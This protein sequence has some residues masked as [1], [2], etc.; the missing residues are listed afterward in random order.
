MSG[1]MNTGLGNCLLMVAMISG[2]CEMF[3]IKYRLGDN[4]DDCAL[5]I[6][7]S[8]LSVVNDNIHDYCLRFGFN[9]VVDKPVFVFEQINFCQMHPVFDGLRWI[10][11]RDPRTCIAKDLSCKLTL[12]SRKT[13]YAWLK[14]VGGCGLS[15][16]GNLPVFGA[17]YHYLTRHETDH[18]LR[19][20]NAFTGLGM[21]YWGRGVELCYTQP[22]DASRLSFF[23]A[24]GITPDFQACIEDYFKLAPCMNPRRMRHDKLDDD[25]HLI[26]EEPFLSEALGC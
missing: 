24:F 19:D 14:A 2:F 17:F 5:F 8:D 9:L 20:T 13:Q 3:Q 16:A 21:M 15:M 18:V 22:S 11:S 10:M 23:L 6:D 7:K 26:Y 12:M 25:T 4:G 1:D